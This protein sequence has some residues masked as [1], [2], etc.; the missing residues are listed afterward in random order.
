MCVCVCVCLCVCVRERV[1]MCVCMCLFLQAFK[2]YL[3]IL[4]KYVPETGNTRGNEAG[5]PLILKK[6]VGIMIKT[7]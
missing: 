3:H 2:K 1:H 4:C 7:K 6:H 5:S